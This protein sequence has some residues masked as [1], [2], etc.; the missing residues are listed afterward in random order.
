MTDTR[1]GE[2]PEMN[3]ERLEQLRHDPRVV[4][5]R[6]SRDLPFEPFVCVDGYIDVR[7]LIGRREPED[8]PLNPRD[9]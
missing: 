6:K 5:H 1:Q 9:R 8:E 7:E 3:D 2:D 4:V